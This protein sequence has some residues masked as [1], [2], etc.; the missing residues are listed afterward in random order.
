MADYFL[1]VPPRTLRSKKLFASLCGLCA[2]CGQTCDSIRA[3]PTKC[4]PQRSQRT[5]RGIAGR[6]KVKVERRGRRVSQRGPNADYF[7]CVPPR[8]L[9]SE[10]LFAF[11]CGLCALCG[12][13]CDSTRAGPAKCLPQRSQ[14]TQRGIAGKSEVEFE[15]RGRRVSQRTSNGRCF[16]S[17][18]LREL[19]V[20]KRLTQNCAE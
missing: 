11:V 13:T 20:H 8:T 9:R 2:L 7:L 17:A 3:G 14:R 6:S 4:L 10:K 1:C 12:Q 5:Q 19:C 15:R 18:F 16:P